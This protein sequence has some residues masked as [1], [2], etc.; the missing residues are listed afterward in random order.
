MNV[1]QE[2]LRR[3]QSQ[4]LA[5]GITWDA[6]HQAMSKMSKAT[7]SAP[8]TTTTGLNYYNLEPI[9]KRL[10]NSYTPLRN[11]LP[12]TQGPGGTASNWRAVTK[13]DNAR[14]PMGIAD[15]FRASELAHTVTEFTAKYVE[16][17]SES[18]TTFLAQ[19]AGMGFDDVRALQ[20][21]TGLRSTQNNEERMLIGG[22]GT[23]ALATPG[24]VTG[25][26]STTAGSLSTSTTYHVRVVALTVEGLGLAVQA[27]ST[28]PAQLATQ[29]TLTEAGPRARTYT[30]N[31]GSSI[32]GTD[33]TAATTT[34]TSLDCTVAAVPGAAAYA[35]AI[36]STATNGTFTKI[37]A[38]NKANI[39][40][41]LT[42]PGSLPAGYFDTVGTNF[43]ADHSQNSRIFDGILSIAAKTDSGATVTSLDGAKMTGDNAAGIVEW[44][45]LLSTLATNNKVSPS[46]AWVNFQQIPDVTSR[47]LTGGSGAQLY[48]LIIQSGPGQGSVMAGTRVASYKNKFAL[49]PAKQ[50][51]TVRIHPDIPPGTIAFTSVELPPVS[52]PDANITSVLEVETL[53]EYTQREWPLTARQYESGV[54]VTEVLKCY[55]PFAL[56]VLQNVGV[57]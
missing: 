16:I 48:Q 42:S 31:G 32:V 47:V 35:W 19:L 24:A 41:V 14:Q 45:A 20:A 23:Y 5:Q 44:D 40:A 4:L 39:G 6:A 54:Y 27:T 51:I 52:F 2:T 43:N 37:T 46:D 3:I 57:G 9:A 49:D 15:G 33:G 18:S 17:G 21:I 53:E 7:F 36:G 30:V 50:D 22:L 12:R 28:N 25:A 26:N 13:I 34:G 1:T 55:A 10:Y 11:M 29:L 8:S 38:T 56:G